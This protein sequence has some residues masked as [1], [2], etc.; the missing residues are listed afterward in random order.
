M[1]R[2]NDYDLLTNIIIIFNFS[3]FSCSS[4]LPSI[5]EIFIK[6]NSI[7]FTLIT[8]H[9]YIFFL[10]SFQLQ[11]IQFMLNFH[12]F[13]SNI[14]MELFLFKSFSS[15]LRLFVF[16]FIFSMCLF[17][18]C[19]H[20]LCWGVI[21]IACVRA[22]R[23][24]M[25]MML[26][27]LKAFKCLSWW[28]SIWIQGKFQSMTSGIFLLSQP[29]E[30]KVINDSVE[31]N[32]LVCL[33][34]TRFKESRARIL[35][36]N[37][38]GKHM[39]VCYRCPAL[40]QTQTHYAIKTKLVNQNIELN[41]HLITKFLLLLLTEYLSFAVNGVSLLLQSIIEGNTLLIGNRN[42]FAKSVLDF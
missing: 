12:F 27:R 23:E 11:F 6:I 18:G 32:C 26:I 15:D 33:W 30:G 17:L 10:F 1:V 19:A 24:M 39:K 22:T 38:R 13:S 28:P 37:P 20:I 16:R 31:T 35:R 4:L 42:K 9:F 3:W 29:R 21:T 14:W 5:S 7:Y 41:Q 8:L 40:H 36:A 2:H 34:V 25:M